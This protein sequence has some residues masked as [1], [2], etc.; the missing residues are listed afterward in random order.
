MKW[1]NAI[2]NSKQNGSLSINKRTR[3]EEENEKPRNEWFLL[4]AFLSTP[5]DRMCLEQPTSLF[6]MW[7]N[8]SCTEYQ[9][10]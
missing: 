2:A 5:L 7:S 3:K 1:I 9:Y 6:H 10:S 4:F 8:K